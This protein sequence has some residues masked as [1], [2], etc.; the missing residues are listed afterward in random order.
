VRPAAGLCDHD[1][2]RRLF[3]RFPHLTPA[4]RPHRRPTRVLRGYDAIPVLVGSHA[5]GR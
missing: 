3:E 1:P 4:G 5:V 2:L